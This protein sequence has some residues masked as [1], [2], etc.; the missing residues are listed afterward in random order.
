MKNTTEVIWIN[1]LLINALT[2][3]VLASQTQS[4]GAW[5]RHLTTECW[6]WRNPWKFS[7]YI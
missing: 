4:A 6:R 1:S 3:S 5:L 2:T 7:R